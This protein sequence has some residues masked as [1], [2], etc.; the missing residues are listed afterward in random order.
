MERSA[1]LSVKLDKHLVGFWKVGKATL[2]EILQSETETEYGTSL[3]SELYKIIPDLY[4][5]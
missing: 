2:G 3:G 1:G 4:F 5:F